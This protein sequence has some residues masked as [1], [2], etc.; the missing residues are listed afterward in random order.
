MARAAF[1]LDKVMQKIGLPGKAFVPLVLGFG[2]NVPSIM[3]TRTLDQ[4]RERKLAAAMAPFM[5]CGARLACVRA[6]CSGVLPGC[7][8]EHCIR[9]LPT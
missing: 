2:C 3:A 7:G 5:S 1:V 6:I 4:E 8:S 9:T